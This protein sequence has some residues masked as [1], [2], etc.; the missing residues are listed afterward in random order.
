LPQFFQ[1]HLA[2]AAGIRYNSLESFIWKVAD[3][4][5]KEKSYAGML[6]QPGDPELAEGGDP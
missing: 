1:K 4:T 3:I 5:E 6:Y 2:F